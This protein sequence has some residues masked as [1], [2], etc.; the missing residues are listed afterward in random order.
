MDWADG[1]RGPHLEIATS[2]ARRVGVLAGPGTG[3]TT[4]GL[5]RRVARLLSEGVPGTRILLVSF[6]RVAAA[7]LREKVAE[8]EIEGAEEVRATTLHAYC[9]GLLMRESVLALTGRCPRILMNHERDL[10]LRD[11]GGDFGSIH[12]RRKRLE[13]LL[14]GWSRTATEHPGVAVD[15]EDLDFEHLVIRWLARHRAMLIGEVVPIANRFLSTNPL[16]EELDAWDH[17]V[18]DEYQDLNTLEQGLL[19]TLATRARS[20]CIAGDDDQSIYSV[21]YANPHGIRRFLTRP[22]VDTHDITVCGRSP[23]N[24]VY[25]ANSL[26]QQAPGRDKVPLKP[27][28]RYQ[29][30]DVSIVQWA[31]VPSE[32]DG[33]VSAIAADV[34]RRDTEPGEILV[35][36]NWRKMG[37]QIRE[38]LKDLDIPARSFFTE[39]ELGSDE[40]QEAVALFRLVVDRSD[41]PAVRVL[42]GLG[43]G[44]GRSKAY[45]R[46]LK[47]CHSNALGPSDALR[48]LAA[49]E[50]LG[51]LRVPSLVERY[52]RAMLRVE[53]LKTLTL[54]E[55][56]DNLFPA[57]DDMLADLR[58][59]AVDALEAAEH[60]SQVLE[61]IVSAVT[62]DD[63]PQQP[64]FVRVM[65]LH[66]SKGLTAEAVYVVSAVNG[67]LPT[68]TSSDQ[69][70][71][72]AAVEEGRRLFYV[73]LT[74]T[75]RQL[76]IS[77]SA[78]MDLADANARRVKYEK[79]TIR[80]TGEKHTV[81]T[82][83]SPYISELGRS[84][85]QSKR[86]RIWLTSRLGGT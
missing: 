29:E 67:I 64:N 56:V 13:A 49:G 73:A 5:M 11:V 26:I 61:E 30:G 36:T 74:R 86:G 35:L 14:A 75:A 68:I 77:S 65:S 39:E 21:R 50:R 82:I 32:V 19:E 55:L 70:E 54:P 15:G 38:G 43:E 41:L 1:L 57:S 84:A 60:P 18:V 37:E 9:L 31:D 80:W 6:T 27:L 81:R 22:G 24:I 2:N 78:K 66:K 47:Y 28:D 40:G 25:M 59:I 63:V 16:S 4:F 10:M 8:L 79:S 83:A 46:L 23:A 71:V 62:Q 17:I 12:D 45:Q 48:R 52:R 53:H 44:S 85:P 34:G 3:K 58:N 69:A 42:V 7:D 76:V 72:E 51:G 33:I 20:L